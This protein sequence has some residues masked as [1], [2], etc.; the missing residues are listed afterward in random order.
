MANKTQPWR[1][2]TPLSEASLQ[3]IQLELIRR[4]RHNA[5]DGERVV[6]SLLRHRGLWSAALMD[7]LS[8]GSPMLKLR[9]CNQ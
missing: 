3:E 1:S 5:F 9:D 2:T 8:T 6:E 4:H 7:C